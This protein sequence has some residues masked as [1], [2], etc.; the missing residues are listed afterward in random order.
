MNRTREPKKNHCEIFIICL[1]CLFLNIIQLL[2]QNGCLRVL[3]RLVDVCEYARGKFQDKI[4]IWICRTRLHFIDDIIER[5]K[6]SYTHSLNI[7]GK[8][9]FR[10]EIIQMCYQFRLFRVAFYAQRK[11]FKVVCHAFFFFLWNSQWKKCFGAS[12]NAQVYS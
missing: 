3:V 6:H 7:I 9:R 5:H 1:L 12:I 2:W 8:K 11:T 4:F 10:F